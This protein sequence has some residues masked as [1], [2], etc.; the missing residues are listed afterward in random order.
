MS[1]SAKSFGFQHNKSKK[2]ECNTKRSIVL[3]PIT[4]VGGIELTSEN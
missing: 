4:F 2:G 3:K 1:T